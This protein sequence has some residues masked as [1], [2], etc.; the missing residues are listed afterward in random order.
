MY[1]PLDGDGPA[2]QSVLTTPILHNEPDSWH[3]WLSGIRLTENGYAHP[4]QASR[5]DDQQPAS[6]N[7]GMICPVSNAGLTQAIHMSR[8]WPIAANAISAMPVGGGLLAAR[9]AYALSTVLSD[10]LHSVLGRTSRRQ[11]RP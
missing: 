10:S 2:A 1:T 7:D 4:N 6:E 9:E 3:F 8:V 11:A 5:H